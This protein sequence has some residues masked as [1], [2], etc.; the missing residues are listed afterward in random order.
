VDNPYFREAFAVLEGD[1]VALHRGDDP[2]TSFWVCA[3]GEM[4]EPSSSCRCGSDDDR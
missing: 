4:Q 3:A 1:Y 2:T